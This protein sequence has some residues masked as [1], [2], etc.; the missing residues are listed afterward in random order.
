MVICPTLS[1][2]YTLFEGYCTGD[3]YQVRKPIDVFVLNTLNFRWTE[4][5]KP[6]RE[7]EFCVGKCLLQIQIISTTDLYSHFAPSSALLQ[8][9]LHSLMII[10]QQSRIFIFSQSQEDTGCSL[11]IVFLSKILEYSELWPFFVFPWCQFVYTHQAGRTP[12]MQQ[13]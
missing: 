3:N 5:K 7:I 11:N 12:A 8:I 1:N 4:I 2:I 13:N 6:V 9:S 10:N